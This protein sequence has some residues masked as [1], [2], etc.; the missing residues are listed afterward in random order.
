MP[1]EIMGMVSPWDDG[2][3]VG[4]VGVEGILG[5]DRCKGSTGVAVYH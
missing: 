1:I 4:W 5:F 2:V 3:G